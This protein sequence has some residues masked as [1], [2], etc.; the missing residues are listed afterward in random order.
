MTENSATPR[1]P[2]PANGSLLTCATGHDVLAV[3]PIGFG[4]RVKPCAVRACLECLVI[5]SN[6]R[7][8][9][10]ESDRL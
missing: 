4:N 6:L 7:A 10:S 9:D 1:L 3:V 2:N 8:V 5:Y